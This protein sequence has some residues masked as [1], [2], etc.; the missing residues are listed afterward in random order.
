[1]HIFRGFFKVMKNVCE[2]KLPV[3]S[4]RMIPVKLILLLSIIEV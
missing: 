2:T 3:L 1:M 4:N